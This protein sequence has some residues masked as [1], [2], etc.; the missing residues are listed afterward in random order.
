VAVVVYTLYKMIRILNTRCR[1]REFIE[2]VHY[3]IKEGPR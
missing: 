2:C 1:V 3:D